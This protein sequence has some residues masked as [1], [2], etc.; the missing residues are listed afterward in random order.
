[1]TMNSKD[2]KKY[3]SFL[4]VKEKFYS[5]KIRCEVCNS[6]NHKVVRE[7]ISWGQNKFGKL[8]VYCC[9]DCGFL[10]QNPRFEKK[11]YEKFYSE[12]YRKKIYKN[13][14]PSK[15]FLKDQENRGN[16]IFKFLKKYIKKKRGTIL[17]VGCSD[18]F[19]SQYFCTSFSILISGE[20][21]LE[22]SGIHALSFLIAGFATSNLPLPSVGLKA[23]VMRVRLYSSLIISSPNNDAIN[24]VTLCWPS[25]RILLPEEVVPS[26]KR[27]SGFLQAIR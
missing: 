6:K 14:I 3:F 4:G 24:A 17:D 26:F 21:T 15:S 25:I 13:L 20:I 18:G 9:C 11:F 1:M 8:P 2:I 7:K 5:K 27:T 12:Y 10:F 23:M 19:F 22:M 16:N